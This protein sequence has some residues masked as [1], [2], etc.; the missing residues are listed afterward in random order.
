MGSQEEAVANYYTHTWVSFDPDEPPRCM[1]C[2]AATYHV[3][4][5]YPCGFQI[6]RMDTVEIVR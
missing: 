3:A 6:P 2:D 5:S 1:D 4:A